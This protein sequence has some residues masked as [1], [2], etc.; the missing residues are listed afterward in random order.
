MNNITGEKGYKEGHENDE[1]KKGHH[2]KEDHKKS[3]HEEDGHKKK[4]HD[5]GKFLLDMQLYISGLSC[6]N[7]ARN[8]RLSFGEE[9]RR[10][11][12]EGQQMGRARIFQERTLD[13]G[14]ARNSQIRR[15][16]EGEEVLR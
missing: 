10:K 2:D 1:G 12:R 15:V 11:G 6:M 5:G 14:Q 4:H 3:Y 13:Q 9:E 7:F 16:Q 8:R